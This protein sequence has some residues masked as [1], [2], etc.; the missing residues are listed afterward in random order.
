[1]GQVLGGDAGAVV[2][3]DDLALR[4][5]GPDRDLHRRAVRAPLERVVEQVGDRPLEKSSLSHN[6]SSPGRPTFPCSN[7]GKPASPMHVR[8]APATQAGTLAGDAAP[9]SPPEPR[10]QPTRARRQ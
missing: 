3:H 2:A 6:G 10:P 9:G 7:W 4:T 8:S 1:M 5:A